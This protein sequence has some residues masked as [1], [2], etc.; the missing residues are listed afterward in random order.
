VPLRPLSFSEILDGAFQAIRT[1]PRTM[2]GFAAVVLSITSLLSLV[3]QAWMQHSLGQVMSQATEEFDP[4]ALVDAGLVATLA[5]L[6]ATVLVWLAIVVLNALLVVAV[7]AAVLGEKTSPGELWRRVRRRVPAAVGLSLVTGLIVSVGAMAAGAVLVVP[8][9]LLF[10]AEQRWAGVV[11]IVLGALVALVAGVTL[12]IRTSLA[13]PVLLLEDSSVVTALRRSWRLVS[14][15]FWRVLL[16]LVVVGVMTYVVAMFI[17]VPFSLVAVGVDLAF[18]N[19]LHTRW[20]PTLLSSGVN[21]V[22]QTVSGAV[23]NPWSAAVVALLYVDL[24]MRREG[25]DLELIRAA[26]ARASSS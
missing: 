1:N 21:A 19:Q 9:V 18:D 16:V 14:G 17:Q 2:M 20:L 10:A 7:S 22:G 5:V 25:H 13:G 6:P 4:T 11:V 23:L 12:W 15:S 26:D 8:G 3:P 24:R